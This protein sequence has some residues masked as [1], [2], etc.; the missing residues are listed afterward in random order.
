MPESIEFVKK[1]VDEMASDIP[2]PFF[3]IGGDESFDIGEGTSKETVANVGVGRVHADHYSA[4]DRYIEQT[5]HRQV[6]VYGDMLLRHPDAMQYM[7]KD[8]VIVDWHYDPAN[9]YPSVTTFKSAGFKNII[10]SPGVWGWANFYPN[11]NNAFK[12]ISVFTQIAKRGRG[13]WGVLSPR[14]GMTAGKTYV[15]TIG[16]LMLFSAAADWETRL[17]F[18]YQPV[19]P[20]ICHSLLWYPFTQIGPSRLHSWTVGVAHNLFGPVVPSKSC[21]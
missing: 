16:S 21:Y 17:N 1:L 8:C 7:P 20:K 13:V 10:V 18:R 11:Y 19:Y 3:H 12:N 14:G 15:K 9:D 2:F 5:H 4:T 6:M